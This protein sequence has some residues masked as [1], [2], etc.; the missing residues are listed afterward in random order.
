MKIKQI[1]DEHGNDFRA[2]LECE[3]CGHN[4]KITNGYHDN[5]YHTQV[6]PAKF[7]P[8]CGRNRIGLM[9]PLTSAAPTVAE[10]ATP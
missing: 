5:Y 7:C 4:Q 1:T 10:K 2:I 6:M 9:A 8:A 3:H